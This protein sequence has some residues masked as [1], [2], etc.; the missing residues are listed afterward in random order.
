MFRSH[1][2]IEIPTK[3]EHHVQLH[4]ARI[5]PATSRLLGST[6][7]HSAIANIT[8]KGERCTQVL[9][10]TSERER[11]DSVIACTFKLYSFHSCNL[12]FSTTSFQ[13]RFILTRDLQGNGEI[14]NSRKTENIRYSQTQHI[15]FPKEIQAINSTN[16]RNQYIIMWAQWKDYVYSNYSTHHQIVWEG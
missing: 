4:R 8:W 15:T 12:C 9:E 3:Q 5:E 11:E 10:V 2:F 6:L 7:T 13:S 14:I 16:K 1:R